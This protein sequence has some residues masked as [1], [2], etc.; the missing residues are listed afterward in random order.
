MRHHGPQFTMHLRYR[1]V[2]HVLVFAPLAE[3]VA[4]M[5]LR[6]PQKHDL[7]GLLYRVDHGLYTALQGSDWPNHRLCHFSLNSTLGIDAGAKLI[8]QTIHPS[9]EEGRSW[10]DRI[11]DAASP[12]NQRSSSMSL[13]PARDRIAILRD[14]ILRLEKTEDPSLDSAMKANLSRL[15][16]DHIAELDAVASGDLPCQQHPSSIIA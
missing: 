13:K 6:H 7:S 9:Y 2:L 3:K 11:G 14:I 12:K 8:A 16:L 10:E 5:K 1:N 15:L 4:R